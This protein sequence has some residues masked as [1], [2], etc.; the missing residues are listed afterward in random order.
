MKVAQN[1]RLPPLIVL[2]HKRLKSCQRKSTKSW[3]SILYA[4]GLVSY[5]KTIW[6]GPVMWDPKS[7]L[8]W[9]RSRKSLILAKMCERFQPNP[10]PWQVLTLLSPLLEH[11]VRKVLISKGLA[12]SWWLP[13]WVCEYNLVNLRP[14]GCNAYLSEIP[15]KEPGWEYRRTIQRKTPLPPTSKRASRRL[16]ENHVRTQQQARART[17]LHSKR[18]LLVQYHKI[19]LL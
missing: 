18:R 6:K 16:Q 12:G 11:Q 10:W 17:L 3:Q 4:A 8:W 5:H 1:Q 9:R 13:K 7:W 2:S 15:L 19:T 14:I